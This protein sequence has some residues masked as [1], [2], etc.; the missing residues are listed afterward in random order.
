MPATYRHE[1]FD[2]STKQ[3]ARPRHSGPES[4]GAELLN[5]QTTARATRAEDLAK[6]Q[7][8]LLTNIAELLAPYVLENALDAFV[9]ALQQNLD[10]TRVA[11]ALANQH[12]TLELAAIS[13]QAGAELSSNEDQVLLALMAECVVQERVVCSPDE[14]TGFKLPRADDELNSAEHDTSFATVPL[15]HHCR[16]VGVLLFERNDAAPFVPKTLELLE[17]IAVVSTPILILRREAE[18]G[19]IAHIAHQWN[20]MLTNNFGSWRIG[21]AFLIL[22]SGFIVLLSTAVPFSRSV[23]ADAELVPTERRM[24]TAPFDGFIDEIAVVSGDSVEVG[25]LLGQLEQRELEIEGARRDGDVASAEAQFRTA[26]ADH[27]WQATTIARARLDRERALRALVD[28]RLEKIELRAPI[29]GRIVS[30]DT[31]DATGAP[32]RRGETLFEIAKGDNYEVHLLVHERDIREI[33]VGQKGTLSLT[34]RPGEKLGLLVHTIHPLAE[35][36]DG[37]SRF[38]ILASLDVFSGV[39]PRPGES[40]VAKLDA[41]TTNFVRL[42]GQP[43]RQRLTELWW[44]LT[45]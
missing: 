19:A 1:E 34:A 42:W 17:Q 15:Y 39:S 20:T 24:I 10:I 31:G 37:V 5:H 6:R 23:S 35:R 32:V 12:G 25:Q 9:G 3:T 14:A 16:L 8:W 40:G 4:Q 45:K 41:G 22:L 7:A 2:N 18:R 29:A 30:S 33:H 21:T 28:Q 26:M 38:R 36:I 13:E 11:L 43:I 44:R 27:D